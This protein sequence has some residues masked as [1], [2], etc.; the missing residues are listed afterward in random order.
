MLV[1]NRAGTYRSTHGCASTLWSRRFLL[2]SGILFAWKPEIGSQA[3]IS[4]KSRSLHVT[5]PVECMRGF[6]G[7]SVENRS[8]A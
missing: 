8:I 1:S 3:I 6:Y 2:I 4:L 5:V 7:I